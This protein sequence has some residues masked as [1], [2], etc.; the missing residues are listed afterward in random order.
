MALNPNALTS[1]ARLKIWLGVTSD[2]DNTLLESI[3]NSV[4]DWVERYIDRT[5]LLTTYT[6][7]VYSG[8]GTQKLLLKQFPVS[9]SDS[10]TFQRRD[11][12]QNI[13]TWSSIDSE[14]YF[15]DY[16]TGIVTYP[17]VFSEL[18]RHYRFSYTAGYDYDQAAKTLESLGLGDLEMAVW[19]LCNAAYRK[20]Q[21]TEDVSSESIGD[22]SVTYQKNATNDLEI[23]NIL[24][25]YKRP[26]EY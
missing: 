21:D 7:E 5:L 10:F 23:Y 9:S 8:T 3:I 17:G 11:A 4:S 12:V 16:D 14:Q 24:N 2:T 15:V 26:P 6:N 1:L 19:K 25:T 18:P 20:R 13:D 22:Y